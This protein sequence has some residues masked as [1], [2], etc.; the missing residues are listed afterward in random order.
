MIVNVKF[1]AG[2]VI[3]IF[4]V[5]CIVAG[6]VVLAMN[7]GIWGIALILAPVLGFSISI[8]LI[9]DGLRE[10][11]VPEPESTK[12]QPDHAMKAQLKHGVTGIFRDTGVISENYLDHR[13]LMHD[14]RV[15]Q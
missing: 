7:M 1:A 3:A 11:D 2:V 6:C 12:E 8:P 13:A 15:K 14:F 4:L 5:G 10:M 9:C